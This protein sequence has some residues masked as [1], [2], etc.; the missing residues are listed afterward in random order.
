MKGGQGQDDVEDEFMPFGSHAARVEIHEIGKWTGLQA[1]DIDREKAEAD[2]KATEEK[3]AAEEKAAEEA[4][5]KAKKAADD[6][7]AKVDA[8]AAKSEKSKQ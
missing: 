5:A 3:K 4:K 6:A 1:I 2:K 8:D 7:K